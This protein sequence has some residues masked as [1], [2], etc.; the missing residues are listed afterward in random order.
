MAIFTPGPLVGQISGRIG[1]IV[2][3]HNRG[4]AYWRNGSIPTRSTTI[5]AQQAK[6]LLAL[7]SAA[8]ASLTGPQQQ[9]WKTWATQNPVTNRLGQ[10]ITLAPH[11]AFVQLNTTIILAGGVAIAIPPIIP[12]PTALATLSVSASI[13]GPNA[14]TFTASPI[15][16][17]NVLFILAAV[18][19]NP[20]VSYVQN[21]YKLILVTAANDASPTNIGTELADRFGTLQAGQKLF[22]S[23]QVVDQVTGLRSGPI[24][25]DVVLTA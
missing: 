2:A 5:Y 22:L 9:A 7:T 14:I 13:A 19:D 12:P 6:A 3:S 10:Q 15:G 21:L 24:T 17:D 8:W 1:G 4:G 23:V 16:A 18:S 20:G 25:A 11:A